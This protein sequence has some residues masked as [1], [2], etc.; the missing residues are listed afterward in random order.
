MFLQL[1]QGFF[2]IL[3]QKSAVISMQNAAGDKVLLRCENFAKIPL[4]RLQKFHFAKL[5]SFA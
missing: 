2:C 3:Q 5:Q 4:K 1:N